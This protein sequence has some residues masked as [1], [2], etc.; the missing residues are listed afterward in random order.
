MHGQLEGNQLLQD[1]T[2]KQ[3]Y[4]SYQVLH[5]LVAQ[6]SPAL[7]AL[8]EHRLPL[9]SRAQLLRVELHSCLAALHALLINLQQRVEVAAEL[10]G[11]LITCGARMGAMAQQQMT[12]MYKERAPKNGKAGVRLIVAHRP[13]LIMLHAPHSCRH[14]LKA[15]VTPDSLQGGC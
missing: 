3:Q 15:H 7:H 4:V 10:A 12:L 8:V 13:A 6:S 5:C 1:S 14:H 9:V 11:P 2:P